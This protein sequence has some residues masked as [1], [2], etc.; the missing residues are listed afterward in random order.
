[1]IAVLFPRGVVGLGTKRG[2]PQTVAGPFFR[3]ERHFLER[4][5][6]TKLDVARTARSKNRVEVPVTSVRRRARAAELAA[7]PTARSRTGE[8]WTQIGSIEEI[9]ELD[10]ELG[11]VPFLHLP[12]L[13]H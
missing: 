13:G 10:S 8:A 4:Q 2:L 6:Q 7:E 12:K 11:S 5:L 9:E 1:M 3:I